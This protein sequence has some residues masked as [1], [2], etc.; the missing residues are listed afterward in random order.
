[1]D[2]FHR[3]QQPRS[4]ASVE[5][6]HQ[7]I[8]SGVRAVYDLCEKPCAA[9]GEGDRLVAPIVRIGRST[10]P[11]SLLESRNQPAHVAKVEIER[12]GER[13]GLD[14][15]QSIYREEAA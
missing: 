12:G 4:L 7:R 1:M 9:V 2:D 15:T 6:G 8:H 11:S 3:F 10:H 14:A 13:P 5:V